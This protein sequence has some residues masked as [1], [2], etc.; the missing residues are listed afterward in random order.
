MKKRNFMAA[1]IVLALL[2]PILLSKTAQAKMVAGHTVFTERVVEKRIAIIRD[3]YYNKMDKLLI[4]KQKMY[5]DDGVC[6]MNYY[7]HGT[8]LLFGYGTDGKKEY[9]LYFYQN[10]LVRML[11]DQSG[12]SRKTYKQLYKKLPKTWSDSN[13]NA[14]MTMENYARKEM[15]YSI[16]KTNKII[17]KRIVLITRI[18]G[19]TI[20]YHT[21]N[22]YG[23]DGYMW[24]IGK[25]AYK[26][27]LSSAVRISDYSN[28][29]LKSSRRTMAWLRS[30]VSAPSLGQTVYLS[31]D[32]AYVT[33]L[34]IPYFA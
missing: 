10:Q 21:L 34:Q 23:S 1:I 15:A 27:K 22:G 30:S 5:T 29:P 26:A 8:D 24:S 25:K 12:K 3:Y 14:Y 11:V 2:T 31:S 32:G 7:I 4:R 13:L 9:R 28:S 33:K 16:K 19:N 6:T 18:C 17:S 20:I